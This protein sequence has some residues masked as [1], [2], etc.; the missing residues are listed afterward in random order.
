MW[1]KN[2][3]H[4]LN[5]IFFNIKNNKSKFMNYGYW[6]NNTDTL[7]KA[8]LNL[9]QLLLNYNNKH[10]IDKKKLNILDIGCGNGEQLLYWYDNIKQLPGKEVDNK[11]V[12]NNNV[13]H[14]KITGL[15]IN[16][17][18]LIN[19][20]NLI[21][22][23]KLSKNIDVIHGDACNLPFKNDLY[24]SVLSLESA[25]H[26]NSRPL[27]FKEVYKVLKKD[28]VFIIA[29]I[30]R[31]KKNILTEYITYLASIC[32]GYPYSNSESKDEWVHNLKLA[33]FNVEI[34]DITNNTFGNFY[35]YFN[36]NFYNKNNILM[37]YICKLYS[38]LWYYLQKYFK[39]YTYVVAKC[40]KKN[41]IQ[42]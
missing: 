12:D 7:Y 27:F 2:Y 9:C 8:N 29:D 15:D 6:T 34:N 3:T 36:D 39:P 21:N 30:T 23:H 19:C 38:I 31:N 24:D 33:G 14:I 16:K 42:Y 20:N 4:I 1:I 40:T 22:T 10:H 35:H 28:G 5:N 37:T 25:F 26:Y 41:T 18:N 11:D 17:D 13:P 32:M